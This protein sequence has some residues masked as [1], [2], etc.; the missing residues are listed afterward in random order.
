MNRKILYT[1]FLLFAISS[2]GFAQVKD[3]LTFRVYMGN[4]MKDGLFIPSQGDTVRVVGSFNNWSTT[5]TTVRMSALGTDSVYSLTRILDTSSTSSVYDHNDTLF[6]KFYRTNRG[7]NYENVANNRLYGPVVSGQHSTPTYFFSDDSTVNPVVSVTFKVN[8]SIKMREGVFLPTSGDIVTVTGD[9]DGWNSTAD[10]LTLNAAD[11]VYSKTV[12]FVTQATTI[13]YKFYKS[14]RGGLDW[15]GDQPTSSKNREYLVPVGGGTPAPTPF[16]NNDSVFVPTVTVNLLWQTDMTPFI[17][18]GW[19]NPTTDS[20][21][22]RGAFTGW[23]SQKMKSNFVNPNI[24]EFTSQNLIATV[25]SQLS[26]KYYIRYKDSVTASHI[27]S[28]FNWDGNVN[29]TANA[30]IS[31]GWGY[32]HPATR[33]DGNDLYTVLNTVN[34]TPQRNWF[35]EIN[36][37]GLLASTDTVTVTLSV[38][39]GPATRYV[40]P[41]VL[42]TDTL[43]LLF[44]DH[45]WWGAEAKIQGLANFPIYQKMTRNSSTDSVYSVTFKVIGKTHYNMM[46]TY[47]Y[48]RSTGTVVD[49]GGGLGGQNLFN[50]RYIMGSVG[51]WPKTYAAPTDQWQKSAPLPFEAAPFST[52]VQ[53][54]KAMPLVFNLY[55]NYPNPFNPTTNIEYSLPQQ[56]NVKL[57]VYNILGQMVME[58]FSG[59]QVAGT[60]VVAFDASRLAS[61][62]YFYRLEAG[63]YVNVKKMVLLK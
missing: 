32:E 43:Y 17:T 29:G 19:F 34:Q 15:E 24:W 48:R 37:S 39:M 53:K 38:N 33:G 2:V 6:Y 1:M 56:S 62:V 58:L 49:Q 21:D 52:D 41:F 55:Q 16:F 44:Q 45:T 20:V 5:D 8:M 51:N 54:D 47:Q 31:D 9:F 25:N 46:Y 35:A 40:D 36:P 59:A 27:F 13:H 26:Y 3:T 18:L 23:S 14:L 57:R 4:M 60:H 30:N 61:G 63:S 7:G 50:S 10:T 42:G 12:P 22:V 28:G 11:S